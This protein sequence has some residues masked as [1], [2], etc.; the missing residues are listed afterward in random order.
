MVGA[1]RVDVVDGEG[2]IGAGLVGID[3]NLVGGFVGV[4]GLVGVVDDGVDVD[5]G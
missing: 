3:T 5:A 4:E 2:G 1:Q